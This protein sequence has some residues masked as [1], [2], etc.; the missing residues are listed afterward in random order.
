M[1]G[2]GGNHLFSRLC[3]LSS[4]KT[5]RRGILLQIASGWR[6][7][8]SLA[9][10]SSHKR[11]WKSAQKQGPLWTQKIFLN[12]SFIVQENWIHENRIQS[13]PL[14][15]CDFV[16]LFYCSGHSRNS[17]NWPVLDLFC[18][19]EMFYCVSRNVFQLPCRKWDHQSNDSFLLN[20]VS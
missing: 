2:A 18:G 15:C 14:C 4:Q 13:R 7:K 5:K 12:P 8:L 6:R 3:H 9:P 17:R 19:A 1:V 10:F 20:W 16:K 11:P